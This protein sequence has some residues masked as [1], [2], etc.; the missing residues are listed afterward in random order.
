MNYDF[1]QLIERKHT[2]SIKWDKPFP[3]DG[4]K[5]P[6]PLW[7]A[8]M[9]FPCSQ[10]IQQALQDK[11]KE[12]IYGYHTGFSKEYKEA[13]CG[14]FQKR[15]DWTIEPSSIFYAGGVV[16]AIAYLI[17]IMSEEGDGIV[18]STPVYYPFKAKIEA[19]KR[20][21][22]ENPLI[23]EDGAYR[24]DIEHLDTLLARDDV[25]GMILC[26]PHN[27]VGRVWREEELMAVVKTAKKYGKW[28]ISDEIHCDLIKAGYRHIPLWKLAKDYADHIV[29]CTAPSKSFNLAG[30]QISNIIITNLKWQRK[31]KEF[32]GERLSIQGP[33]NFAVAACIA[34]Y[35]KQDSELWLEEVNRYVDANDAFVR[36]YLKKHLPHAILTQREGTYLLWVDMRYYCQN[37]KELEQRMWKQ[38]L[39]LDEGYLFGEAGKGYERINLACP[40]CLIEEFVE[41]LCEEF[42]EGN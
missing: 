20:K 36:D 22:V 38:G 42:Q 32:V 28:I 21:V 26:S 13:V 19:T 17:E 11:V 16:A 23:E 40:R 31:W 24:M 14:W 2:G 10:S 12:Q 33:N 1:D 34:A 5:K 30:L 4:N 35:T 6:L 3:I 25:K 8:D 7:V 39:I 15:F 9:D 18:I 29:T 41:R 37:E 27:P